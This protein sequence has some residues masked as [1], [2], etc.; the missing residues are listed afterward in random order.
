MK[1]LMC[2]RS[3]YFRNFG[4]DSRQMLK[5]VEYLRKLGV[6]AHINAGDITD[7]SSYDIVHLFNLASMGETY[8][9]YKIAK[10]YKKT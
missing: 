2:I 8:K 1:V 3:D 9:Y 7:F 4:G 10:S 5:S 6:E